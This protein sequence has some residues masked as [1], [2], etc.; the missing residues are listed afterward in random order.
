MLDLFKQL[1]DTVVIL[2]RKG[3]WRQAPVFEWQGNLFA[4]FGSDFIGLREG[5][6]SRFTTLPDVLWTDIQGVDYIVGEHGRLNIKRKG[7]RVA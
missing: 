2:S 7:F 3:R 4:K 6:G 5:P 1:P